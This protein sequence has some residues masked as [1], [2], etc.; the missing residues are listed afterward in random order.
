MEMTLNNKILT[1]NIPV[2]NLPPKEV[3]EMISLF[4]VVLSSRKGKMT[5]KEAESAA[6]EI[7]E[8]MKESWW[9]CNKDSILKMINEHES[10]SRS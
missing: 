7:S 10:K 1:V 5:L 8:E 9:D 3:S 6:E 2:G 4:K